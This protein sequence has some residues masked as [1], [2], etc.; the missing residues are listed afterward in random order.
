M[1][2]TIF[3]FIFVIIACWYAYNVGYG[4]GRAQ[5]RVETNSYWRKTLKLDRKRGE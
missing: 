1:F 5:G 3:K 2:L 4:Y